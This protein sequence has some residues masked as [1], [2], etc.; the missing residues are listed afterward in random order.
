MPTETLG[1]V[2]TL[3]LPEKLYILIVN[4]ER[5]DASAPLFIPFED[6]AFACPVF[7]DYERAH[8]FIMS[9]HFDKLAT[10]KEITL[11][12]FIRAGEFPIDVAREQGDE[13]EYF[14]LVDPKP[15]HEWH[16]WDDLGAVYP[17]RWVAEVLRDAGE[18][19]GE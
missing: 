11:E 3:E 4:D 14:Y 10:I 5:L 8:E 9:P 7:G 17:M 2:E 13:R 19:R 6:V 16:S 12:G 1:D 18:P 15:L